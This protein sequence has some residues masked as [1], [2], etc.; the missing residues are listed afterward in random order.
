MTD[1]G[2]LNTAALVAVFAA[3]EYA[4]NRPPTVPT[5]LD[6]RTRWAWWP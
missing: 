4:R 3:A 1:L 2:W 5:T 6:R